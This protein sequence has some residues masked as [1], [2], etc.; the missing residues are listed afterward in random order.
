MEHFNEDATIR[1]RAFNAEAFETGE[2]TPIEQ[3]LATAM[4]LDDVIAIAERNEADE[5][6]VNAL[7]EFKAGE[8]RIG[9]IPQPYQ[10]RAK[11]LLDEEMKKALGEIK[12]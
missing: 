5:V 3:E 12:H 9:A 8:Q 1:E 2:M 11:E 7:K 4:D 10:K 6:V